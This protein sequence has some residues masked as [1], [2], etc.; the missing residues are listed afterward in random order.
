MTKYLISRI[1]RGLLSVVVVVAIVMILVYSLINRDDVFKGDTMIQKKLS[2]EKIAYKYE[3]W[4][5]YGYLD[6]F[7]YGEYLNLLVEKG[8]LTL[9]ERNSVARIGRTPDKDST[10]VAQYVAK[11]NEYCKAKGYTVM[12]VDADMKNAT[13]T[14]QGGA[15]LLFAYKDTPLFTRL[16]RFFSSIISVDSIHYVEND[17]DLTGKRGLSFTLYDPIYGGEKFSPAIMGNGTKYKYLVY[18]DNQFPY[19]H[20]NIVSVHLGKSFSINQGIDVFDTLTLNQGSILKRDI[21]FPTGLVENSS[22]DL[23]RAAFAPNAD[24]ENE[25]TKARYTDKYTD[26]PSVKKSMSRMAISFILGIISSLIAYL[27]GVPVGIAMARRKGKWFDKIA[28]A[29]IVFILAVPSLAYIFIFRALGMSAGLPGRFDIDSRKIAMYVLPIISLALPS[30]AGL[31]QWLRRYMIDQMN[32]DYVKF[33][34]SGGLSEREIF[35]KHILKN[36]FI[37]L[38]HGIP[39]VILGAVVGGIITETVYSVPG[40]GRT[41]TDAINLRDNAV[42]IGLTAFYGLITIISRILGDVLMAVVDPRISYTTKAR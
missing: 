28:T 16:W 5:D 26:I 24:L 15:Q 11:F 23:H 8:E 20:Q 33:A 7:T 34:R 21:V 37:P 19:I 36:A 31:M 35:S 39:G 4:E 25:F 38:V 17:E 10:A 13:S 27:V 12:R 29:Y 42:I 32:S 6:Y 41:L 22:N 3:R 14:K 9:E 40:T 1:I 2:N 30:I 18:C